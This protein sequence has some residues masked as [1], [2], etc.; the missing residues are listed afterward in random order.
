M[1]VVP[2]VGASGAI[3]GVMLAFATFFPDTTI[4]VNFFIPLPARI[5]VLVFAGLELVFMFVGTRSGVAH[6]THLAGF[7]FGYLYFLIRLGINPI[8]VFFR[9]R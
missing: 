4:F 5:A 1:A 9:R 6:L 8:S 2:V 3:F 7:L